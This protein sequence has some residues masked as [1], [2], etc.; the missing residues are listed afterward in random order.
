MKLLRN[1]RSKIIKN[2]NGE[3]FPQLEITELVLFPCNIVNNHYEPNSRVLQTFVP[4]TPFG[5]LPKNLIQNFLIQNLY[6][7]KFGLSVN[8]NYKP[9]DRS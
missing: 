3:N 5:I 8:H 9:L 4:N 7:L 2:K 1:T 6:I